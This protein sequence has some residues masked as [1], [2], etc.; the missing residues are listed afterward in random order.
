MTVFSM[1]DDPDEAV[2]IIVDFHKTNS[3]GF[4]QPPGI[5]KTWNGT[6]EM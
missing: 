6:P 5:K 3:V 2:R 1:C 4:K